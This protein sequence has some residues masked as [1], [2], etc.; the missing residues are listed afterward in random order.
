MGQK[1]RA[2]WL[3]I[4]FQGVLISS[5]V[6]V[7]PKVSQTKSSLLRAKSNKPKAQELV[8]SPK[9]V[10][11]QRSM[12]PASSDGGE[13]IESGII[14]QK[15]KSTS[16]LEK[17][18]EESDDKQIQEFIAKIVA[19]PKIPFEVS[20]QERA[21]LE[22][23]IDNVVNL[24]Q[25]TKKQQEILQFIEE[26]LSL[27]NLLQMQKDLEIEH[28]N[29]PVDDYKEKMDALTRLILDKLQHENLHQNIEKQEQVQRQKFAKL[30]E[31]HLRSVLEKQEQAE[32]A[33]FAKQAENLKTL[34]EYI[35]N[36]QK[37]KEHDDYIAKRSQQVWKD[38]YQP[39]PKPLSWYER[40]KEI[41][42]NAMPSSS[43]PKMIDLDTVH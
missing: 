16:S 3:F 18:T 20:D 23:F 19:D 15:A 30:Q 27:K 37:Q 21:E 31:S 2:F 13:K 38:L 5:G 22:K 32:H 36:Y 12:S 25:P 33:D 14:F 40:M 24:Q 11:E 42:R 6:S 35:K 26:E 7:L 34:H 10:D 8:K 4:F 41:V 29:S 43:E 17:K 1:N 39:K 28:K 9:L